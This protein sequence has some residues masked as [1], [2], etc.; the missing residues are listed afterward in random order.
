MA[1]VALR[2]VNTRSYRPTI[3]QKPARNFTQI[4]L[5]Q[6]LQAQLMAN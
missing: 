4:R 1:G 5:L 2:W 3:N 6:L